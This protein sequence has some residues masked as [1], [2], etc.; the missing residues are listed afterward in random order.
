MQ[1]L[2][3]WVTLFSHK[4]NFFLTMHGTSSS[5]LKRNGSSIVLALGDSCK[6]RGNLELNYKKKNIQKNTFIVVE[7]FYCTY[8]NTVILQ[9]DDLNF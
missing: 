2:Q 6:G 5:L 7:Y 8:F 4:K 3:W 1:L 9:V